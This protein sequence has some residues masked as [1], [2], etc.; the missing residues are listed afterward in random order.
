[1]NNIMIGVKFMG[2]NVT[3]VAIVHAN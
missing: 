3:A 2:E 1:M